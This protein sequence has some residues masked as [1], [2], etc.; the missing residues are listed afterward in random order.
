MQA[1]GEIAQLLECL[2]ELRLDAVE[3]RL[4]LGA[5]GDPGRHHAEAQ[6][7]GDEPLL[8]AVVQV[9][10]EPPPRAVACGGD[11]GGREVEGGLAHATGVSTVAACST[12]GAT[13][14]STLIFPEGAPRD[15]PQGGSGLTPR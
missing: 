14:D 13:P 2:G 11:A 10:L 1:V 9:P 4:D 8:R 7:E 3:Q 5:G 12:S 6:R 15:D